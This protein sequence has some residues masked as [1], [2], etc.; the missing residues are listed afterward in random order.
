[1]KTNILDKI[2]KLEKRHGFIT[3]FAIESGSREWGIASKDSD[4]D[5]RLVYYFPK[6]R[7]F[8]ILSYPEDINIIEDNIDIN[9]MELRKFTKLL[10]KNNPTCAEW[11]QSQTI[12]KGYIPLLFEYFV[13]ND[14]FL[15]NLTYHY[16]GL[17]RQNYQKYLEQNK[18][19]SVKRYLYAIKGWL[20]GLCALADILPPI[21]FDK[22]IQLAPGLTERQKEVLNNL[23]IIKIN[24]ERE[25][26]DFGDNSEI[27]QWLC[28]FMNQDIPEKKKKMIDIIPYSKVVSAIINGNGYDENKIQVL[29]KKGC[30]C[31]NPLMDHGLT[32]NPEGGCWNPQTETVINRFIT[33]CSCEC[34]KQNPGILLH[35]DSCKVKIGC[36]D[37]YPDCTMGTRKHRCGSGFTF[38]KK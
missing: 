11:V 8:D 34:H 19:L 35:C 38:I 2:E 31:I 30:I 29:K 21:R 1:M 22:L 17:L 33:D 32:N 3:L 16:K 37:R 28:D 25:T 23:L 13:E 5:V 7:Y 20:S 26:Q 36:C 14:I 12:Y 10:L 27:K 9:G 6:E 15:Y 4:Y 24:A 18:D